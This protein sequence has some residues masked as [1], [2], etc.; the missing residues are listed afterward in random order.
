MTAPALGESCL[1]DIL[2]DHRDKKMCGIAGFWGPQEASATSEA[3][4]SNMAEAIRHRGPDSHGAWHAP[5]AGLGLAH[6]RLAI[7]DLSPAGHQPMFS[8]DKRLCISYNGEIYNF[9]ELRNE[10]DAAGQTPEK[11]WRSAC[12]TEV[13]LAA[14]QAWGLEPALKRFV[15]MFAFALWDDTAQTLTLARD[16]LGIKPLYCGFCGRHF[17]FASE[18]RAMRCH[19]AWRGELHNEALA[20][21]LRLA[22]V[23][24]PLSIYK[25][26][27]KLLPGSLL[28]LTKQGL[29]TRQLPLARRYWS[30]AQVAAA[31]R[32]NPL[33]NEPQE[34]TH[35]LEQQLLDAV[36]LR[37]VADVPLGAMLSGGIDSSTVT[38]LMQECSSLPVRTFSIGSPSREYDEAMAARDVARYL[39]TRH[40]ELVVQ[41]EQAL[42]MARRMPALYDEPFADASQVPTALVCKL[43]REQ[44]TV[45]LTGDGGD[46]LFAGY[47]RH[48]HGPELWNRLRR[49]PGPVRQLAAFVLSGPGEMLLEKGHRALGVLRG[50]SGHPLFRDKLQKVVEA[51]PAADGEAFYE[52]LLAVW[53]QEAALLQQAERPQDPVEALLAPPEPL[54][55]NMDFQSWMMLRDQTGYLP[56]DIL[57]KLDRASMAVSLEGRVPLLDHRVVELA[58]RM[59]PE[60]RTNGGQGKQLLRQVLYRRVPQEMVQR[61]KQGF[62]LPLDAWLR[63]ELRDWAE[64][65]LQPALLEE[66]GLRPAPVLKAWKQHQSGARN[67]QWQLWTVLMYQAWR[68]DYA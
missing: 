22:C 52:S 8:A 32:E 64:G 21:Y 62:D 17:L 65:L 13:I 24:A 6:A 4:L 57:T 36:R 61:P 19:P 9:T 54:P 45:C 33:P 56:E 1:A 41:P 3:I 44:V 31:G 66:G 12:D 15:G 18:L 27:Y 34:L 46:E 35:L 68:Q 40:T 10:L 49:L 60:S 47:N 30:V 51:M 42:E 20:R 26:I 5:S 2:A 29:E 28:V 67:R 58:W 16:R 50:A 38:A 63:K 7:V 39:G 53:Q 59:P 55:Q 48:F 25:G 14:I 11:G 23:P 37:L 43:A